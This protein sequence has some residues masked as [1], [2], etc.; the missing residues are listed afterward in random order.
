M[1]LIQCPECGKDVSDTAMSC[2]NCG[3]LVQP[4]LSKIEQKK[5]KQERQRLYET[6]MTTFIKKPHNK[7]ILTITLIICITAIIL[8]AK[9]IS[10][11]NIKKYRVTYNSDEEMLQDVHG[12]W[13]LYDFK[14]KQLLGCYLIFDDAYSETFVSYDDHNEIDM[15]Q[16]NKIKLNPKDATITIIHN[17]GTLSNTAVYDVVEYENTKYIRM[18]TKEAKPSNWTPFK[19]ISQSTNIKDTQ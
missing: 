10:D 1:A 14:T 19:K 8:F 15:K 6:K 2:P 13:E 4:Y 7:I 3:F 16:N 18:R 17:D 5:A 12:T 11:Y 9:F